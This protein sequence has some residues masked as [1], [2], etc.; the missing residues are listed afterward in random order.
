MIHRAAGERRSLR[1]HVRAAGILFALTLVLSG[2]L[3]GARADGPAGADPAA[4]FPVGALPSACQSAPT[5]ATCIAASVG[6]LNQARA[7]LG[8]PPYTLP[9]NFASL[10]PGEQALVLADSDRALY[11]LPPISGL[12]AALDQDAAAG[13]LNDADPLPSDSNWYGY[14]SNWAEGFENMV[15]AYEAWMYDDGSGSDNLDCTAANSSGCWAHR[16]DI[17]WQFSGGGPLA[18][19]ASAGQD[20]AGN[21]GYAMLIEEAAPGTNPSYIYTW[22]APAPPAVSAPPAPAPVSPIPDRPRRGPASA[23]GA[24]LAIRI[25]AVT[26]PHRLT[27]TLNPSG[28]SLRCSLAG[29]GNRISW[30]RRVK[31]CSRRVTFA[32]LPRGHYRLRVSSPSSTVTRRID[33]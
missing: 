27:V 7:S 9:S 24:S 31:S 10:A 5:D 1:V 25:V 23:H 22:T 4:N 12:T 19:G 30:V 32:H 2:P 33:I 17:L 21:R 11:G 16:H 29:V 26:H 3:A 14:T 13:V 6:Y 15:L 18:M 20:S 8:Q 28:G